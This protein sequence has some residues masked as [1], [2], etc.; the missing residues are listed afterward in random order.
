MDMFTILY[1]MSITDEFRRA[2]NA[3]DTRLTQHKAEE[4]M[5]TVSAEIRSQIEELIYQHAWMLDHHQS[6][7]LADLYAE[8][9][10]LTGIS[11][12]HVGREAIAKYGS[13]RAK[14]KNR[15]ARHVCSNLQLRQIEP[16]RV[17]G[18]LI[19]TLYRHD[20]AGGRPD[21]VAIA[22]AHD[23]Y[24]K[25]EDGGWLFEQRRLELVFE[26]EAHK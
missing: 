26:S 3:S 22:N 6:D 11:L 7:H 4:T 13:A 24:V 9:G 17:E 14:M 16:G 19:I 21:P 15:I 12:N 18:R 25:A 1:T 20:G 5:S 10:K 2:L 8:N 23:I